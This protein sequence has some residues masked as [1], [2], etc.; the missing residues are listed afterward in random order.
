MKK[1]LFIGNWKMHKTLK[2]TESYLVNFLEKLIDLEL[3]DREIA[4]APPFTALFL[5][6]ELV[7]NQPLKLVAQN[8]CWEEK[9]AFTGE[10][11]P[12]MLKELGVSL[13]ILGHSERRHIFGETDEI[14]AKRVWGVYKFGLIPILCIGE[15]LEERQAEKTLEVIESQLK[16]G[17]KYLKEV[18]GD[19][20]VIAYE[21]VWAI[22]TGINA[23]PSQAEEVQSFIR[24][25]LAEIFSSEVAERIRILYGGSVTPE[26]IEDLMKEPNI[27]GVLVGGASLEVE[28]FFKICSIKINKRTQVNTQISLPNYSNLPQEI[29]EIPKKYRRLVIVGASPKSDRPSYIVMDY[30]LKQGFEVLPVNPAYKEI[31]GQK[32]Y[33]SL[34]EIPPEFK[35][36]VIIIFRKSEEVL[37]VV[38][39]AIKVNPKVIWLQEGIYNKEAQSLAEKEGIKI[40]MNLCFKKVHMMGKK[41][42]NF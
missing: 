42:K 35:P 27:D 28:K 18:R 4:I 21:P 26:N 38:E 19:D 23:T 30:L 24:K 14:I 10:I 11:S 39:R 32:T 31:L 22:G 37:P 13:V 41:D 1:Y 33:P 20:L 16:E 15:T 34:E 29:L 5:A 25:K 2:E 12:F 7:K 36:E 3:L 17:L 40:I 6:K 8:S 9:G